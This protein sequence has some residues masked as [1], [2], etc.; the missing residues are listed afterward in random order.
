[1]DPRDSTE[2]DRGAPTPWGA[3]THFDYKEW[4]FEAL[5]DERQVYARSTG[6]AQREL[7]L[8]PDGEAEQFRAAAQSGELVCPVP[9]CPSPLLTTRG[10]RTRRHHFVHRQA[11]PDPEHQRA[12]VRRIATALITDWIHTAHPRSRVETDVTVAGVSVTALVTGPSGLR[13]AVVFVDRRLGTNAWRDLDEQLAR[14]RVTRGWIFAPRSF[15]RFPRPSKDARPD[16]PVVT[17]RE[18]GDIVLDRPV[19]RDMRQVGQWPLLLNITTREVANLIVPH[20]V[21]AR[22][23]QLVPPASADRVLHLHPAPLEECRLCRDG[24]ATPAVDAK[25]LATPRRYPTP[26]RWPSP[27]TRPPTEPPADSVFAHRPSVAP[28]RLNTSASSAMVGRLAEAL[29]DS[30]GVT[31]LASL[32]T[33]LGGYDEVD[34]RLLR[35]LLYNLRVEGVLEFERPLGRFT[36]IRRRSR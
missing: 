7:V 11:P 27:S 26:V 19:F 13:F 32:I 23:L 35:E 16:D 1:V 34:E 6:P 29:D 18:R 17:D 28:S 14:Q 22:R 3:N 8:L 5:G 10:P 25:V 24:I 33:E 21:T 20:G 4:A 36:A 9:G 31:T 2:S 30:A 15:L 12:Y